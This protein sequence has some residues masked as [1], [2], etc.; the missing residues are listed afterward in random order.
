MLAIGLLVLG[1]LSRFLV[2]T[3]N[4]TPVVAIALFGG[5]YLKKKH[6]LIL[7]LTLFLI[8]D[9][10]IGFHNI[11][12]F[13]WGSVLIIALIGLGMKKHESFTLRMGSSIFSAVLF[14][15][16]TN[17]GVWLL[18]GLYPQTL[19]GFLKCYSMAVPFFRGTLLST[20]VYSFVLF[21]LYEVIA[22]RVKNTRLATALL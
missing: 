16:A 10:V 4:F 15:F 5:I 21:G 3:P 11:M 13:T 22:S 2:H 8:S 1:I 12:L 18:S 7:P 9:L 14:F 17:F 6:A 20:L 19:A